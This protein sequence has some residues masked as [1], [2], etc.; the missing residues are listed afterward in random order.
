MQI[1]AIKYLYFMR[2]GSKNNSVVF[3]LFDDEI[4]LINKKQLTIDQVYENFKKNPIE[5][6]DK[7]KQRGI[8]GLIS[9]CGMRGNNFDSSNGTG[10]STVLEGISYALY[11]MIMRRNVNTEKTG[12]AGLAVVTRINKKYIKDMKESYVEIIF[13]SNGKIYI[14]KRGRKFTKTHNNSSPI[15][16]FRC[17]NDNDSQSSH[18]KMDTQD[19]IR[20]IIGME[21]DVF[22]N[23]V[24]FGQNDAGKFVSGTDK[25]KK[26]TEKHL[27]E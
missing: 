13:E 21:Y 19:A 22:C 16:E 20:E 3:D 5:R 17:L 15:H 12:E 25:V 18:R 27:Q 26:E 10:K 8:D 9:I 11:D 7:I 4:D 6:I 24:L 23:S 1:Y 14:L 2:F